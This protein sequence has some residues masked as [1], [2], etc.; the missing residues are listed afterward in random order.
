VP[1]VFSSLCLAAASSPDPRVIDRFAV[2]L[3]VRTEREKL[4]PVGPGLE[5][6]RNSGR[7]ADGIVGAHGE[8]IVV[9]LHLSRTG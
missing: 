2:T 3:V 1:L 9:E 7:D 6:P 4:E 5:R 8:Q